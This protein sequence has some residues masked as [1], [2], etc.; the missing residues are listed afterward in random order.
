MKKDKVRGITK[1]VLPTLKKDVELVLYEKKNLTEVKR[2]PMEQMPGEYLV[3]LEIPEKEMKKYAYHYQCG[4]ES[5]PDRK[6]QCFVKDGSFGE[7]TK[8]PC[9]CGTLVQQEFDWGESRRP[10]L[11]YE[12]M[13]VYLAHIRGFTMHASSKVRGR[14]TFYG[15]VQK[16]PYLKELGITTVELQPIYEYDEVDKNG[17][18]NYWGYQEGYYYAPRAAYSYKADATV[19]CKE[20]IK[21]FHENG[22][23]VV[24][25]FYFPG[26]VSRMEILNIL[27]YWSYYYQV[28]G[29]HLMGENIP[30]E[31]LAR[32]VYLRSR[33]LWYYDFPVDALYPGKELPEKKVLASYQDGY[34]Y[35][36]RR[37]LKG[38]EGCIH[39][40][41]KRMTF[42]PSK[43]GNINFITNYFGFTMWDNVSYEQKH[44]ENN[45]EKNKDGNDYNG[46]WNCG[47]EGSTKKKLIMN[48]RRKQYKNAFALLMFSQGTPLFFMGDEFGNSQKGNNNPYC[49]DNEIAWLNWNDLNRNKELYQY[50][51]ELIAFRKESGVFHMEK[52]CMLMDYLSCGY[53]DLS[54]HGEEAYKPRWD[55][56]SRQAGLLFSGDYVGKKGELTY[57]AIN[58]H[59]EEQSFAYPKLK[60]GSEI[61]CVFATEEGVKVEKERILLPPRSICVCT[62]KRTR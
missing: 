51:K 24:L 19:E 16:I 3:S 10:A 30:V 6:A 29:F 17:K 26:E 23:E 25:Q 5:F 31:E 40:A 60:K 14:G 27:Q 2:I 11:A 4:E 56:Y 8:L 42:L 45:G 28:D 53:P 34:M 37:L 59:W 50:V 20:M 12:D 32:D 62:I 58:M 54:F 36:M 21:A 18:V 47:A 44:N 52:E 57:L 1:L 38:D 48:L 13:V 41:I 33:K 46:S 35:D 15:M 7:K 9:K 43:M 55:Y 39:T 61:R 49:Q 22:M